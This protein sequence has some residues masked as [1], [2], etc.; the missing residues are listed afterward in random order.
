MEDVIQKENNNSLTDSIDADLIFQNKKL[1]SPCIESFKSIILSSS[2]FIKIKNNIIKNCQE[3]KINEL[4]I[5]PITWKIILNIFPCD[6]ISSIKNWVEITKKERLDYINKKYSKENNNSTK[7]SKEYFGDPLSTKTTENNTNLNNKN[8]NDWDN[9]FNNN[10]LKDIIQRDVDRTFQSNPLFRINFIKQI[11]LNVLFIWSKENFELSYRQGMSDILGMILIALFP[12]YF[13]INNE[14]NLD[15]LNF[16]SDEMIYDPLKF[17]KSFYLFFHDEKYFE[18]DIFIIFKHLMNNGLIS[19]Y[20]NKFEIQDYKNFELFE[21]IYTEYNYANLKYD[22][23][24]LKCNKI[25]KEYIKIYDQQLFDSLIKNEIDCT[26]FLQKWLK[27]LLCREFS[28]E[29]TFCFWDAIF[30]ENYIKENNNFDFLDFLCAAMI[31]NVKNSIIGHNLE[32]S[33]YILFNYPKIESSIYLLKLAY[34]IRSFIERKNFEEENKMNIISKSNDDKNQNNNN[35]NKNNNDNKEEMID[36]SENKKRNPFFNLFG[37][38]K[39]K[40]KQLIQT[41]FQKNF[42]DESF[43]TKDKK[44]LNKLYE[45]NNKYKKKFDKNDYS[46]FTFILNI[47]EEKFNK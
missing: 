25:V 2:D 23:I 16:I 24:Y 18:C 22:F 41:D 42:S 12:F 9:F 20:Q 8:N 5:R 36:K 21:K 28:Y 17:S 14:N 37:K 43:N 35:V 33:L 38:N 29:D 6:K 39:D 31:I 34:K 40:D 10:K 11:L 1:L 32:E 19:F 15:S 47:L 7:K 26:T 27:C 46:D 30:V 44:I 13:P 45:I 3:G 4:L